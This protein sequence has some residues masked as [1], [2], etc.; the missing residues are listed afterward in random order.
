MGYPIAQ[1]SRSGVWA[2]AQRQHGVIARRQLLELGFSPRSLKHEIAKGRLY[3]VRRGV[4]ALGRPQLTRY[5]RWMAA[6]LSCGSDAVLSHE[7]AAALWE[8][9]PVRDDLIELSVPLP[10]SHRRQGI[11]VH[12]RRRLPAEELTRRHRIPVTRPICT[13]VDIA[14]RLDRG[15]LEAAVNEA[16]K[17]DLTDPEKLRSA[18]DQLT[19]RPGVRALRELL[20]RRSFT[21]TDSELERRFLPITRRAGLPPPETGRYVNGF[22]ADFYWPE[23]RL[24][25]E[26][27]GLRYH[28]TPG[29]QAKDRHR[30]HAH[31]AAGVTPLRFTQAQVR[32]EADHVQTTLAAVAR[33]LRRAS[34]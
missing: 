9:R 22:R 8:I 12:R 21:L 10:A 16:D 33:R 13:L 5:G 4:Y 15:Q 7:S 23:L 3:P 1:P 11:V 26:T 17:R 19:H 24:V 32:F 14:A 29:Q 27:D 6:L 18:L 20:D 2:L 25:V 31:L 34:L 28:R 30:D